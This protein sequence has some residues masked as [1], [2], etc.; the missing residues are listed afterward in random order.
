MSESLN[1]LHVAKIKGL[2]LG[3][4][5]P[6]IALVQAGNFLHVGSMQL[7]YSPDS[8]QSGRMAQKT[9]GMMSVHMQDYIT[10]VGIERL[11]AVLDYRSTWDSSVNLKKLNAFECKHDVYFQYSPS[12]ALGAG[13]MYVWLKDK[14]AV[15]DSPYRQG[16]QVSF[17]IRWRW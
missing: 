13:W 16:E 9:E 2:L 5:V 6:G 12:F 7:R 17:I 14:D 10:Y 15:V 3:L 11:T 4:C 8:M 1:T